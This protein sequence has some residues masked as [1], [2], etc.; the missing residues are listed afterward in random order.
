MEKKWI[1]VKSFN[2]SLFKHHLSCEMGSQLTKQ[3]GFATNFN[4][5]SDFPFKMQNMCTK[6]ETGV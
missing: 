1:L 3:E 5:T 6:F 4:L 2:V